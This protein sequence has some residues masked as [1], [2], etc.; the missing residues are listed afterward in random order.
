MLYPQAA[1]HLHEDHA[2]YPKR[3]S[4]AHHVCASPYLAVESLEVRDKMC[5]SHEDKQIYY[6]CIYMR[7][8]SRHY[9]CDLLTHANLNLSFDE[10]S[11]WVHQLSVWNVFLSIW[12]F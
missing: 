4:Y 2:K 3:I 8:V 1:D 9:K 10:R 12:D 6:L 11:Q 5:Q 7:N